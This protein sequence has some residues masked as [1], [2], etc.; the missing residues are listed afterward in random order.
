MSSR[1]KRRAVTNCAEGGSSFEVEGS[2]AKHYAC[3]GSPWTDGGTLP[4]EAAETGSWAIGNLAS[5]AGRGEYIAL[6]FP[7]RL[8]ESLSAADVHYRPASFP[9]VKGCSE[10]L[11]GVPLEECEK[12][13]KEEEAQQKAI[14]AVCPGSVEE[15]KAIP[16]NLCVYEAEN[17]G[18]MFFEKIMKLTSNPQ[19][20]GAS[21]AGAL[22]KMTPQE[23]EGFAWGAW[24][25][26]EK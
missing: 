21:T 26:T 4:P 16:G 22:L 6:S 17:N 5:N 18:L 2:G 24:A 3:N 8:K 25:V 23:E 14:E 13:V 10:E 15:P 19:E 11:K 7:I 12:E 1:A 9:P 20:E